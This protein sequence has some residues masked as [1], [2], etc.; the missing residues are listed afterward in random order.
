[1]CWVMT[2]RPASASSESIMSVNPRVCQLTSPKEVMT[3]P[4]AITT[5]ERATGGDMYSTPVSESMAI[6]T[7]G[8]PALSIWMNATLRYMYTAL[9]NASVAACVFAALGVFIC[10]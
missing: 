7:T 8:V 4:R 3:V 9:P 5:V 6:T 1:M 2:Q 10:R